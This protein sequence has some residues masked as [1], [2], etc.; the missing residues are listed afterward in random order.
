MV[1]TASS[2]KYKY[3]KAIK[4]CGARERYLKDK[5][6]N[7]NG[8]SYDPHEIKCW[9]N[10]ANAIIDRAAKDFSELY[11]SELN[12]KSDESLLRHHE[13]ESC[14]KFFKSEYFKILS[15]ASPSYILNKIKN[16]CD[17]IEREVDNLLFTR[18]GN[19][20]MKDNYKRKKAKNKHA[21]YCIKMK[22]NENEYISLLFQISSKVNKNNLYDEF[23]KMFSDD[24]YESIY[25]VL[26][27]RENISNF[28]E[29]DCFQI[30]KDDYKTCIQKSQ[31]Q[32]TNRYSGR[33]VA[34]VV[35]N[36]YNKN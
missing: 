16:E 14:V 1:S 21:F 34:H 7:S 18:N 15:D 3:N 27:D 5:S 17:E 6:R 2:K 32:V 36:T 33:I 30:T 10:L 19:N 24:K 26:L 22:N 8:F 31:R 35:F 11:F 28:I 29:D 4:S 25:D 12:T 20:M 23:V 13:K 9:H